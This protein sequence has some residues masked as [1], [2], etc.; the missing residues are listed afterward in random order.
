MTVRGMII[1]SEPIL[2]AISEKARSH[3]Q[4]GSRHLL[5]PSCRVRTRLYALKD[6]R[7]KCG[8]C[9]GKFT[10]SKKTDAVKL[11]QI[12]DLILCFC[13]NF[14]ARQASDLTSYRYRLV[15]AVY[16]DIRIL[17][18]RQTLVPGKLAL[19][20]AVEHCNRAVR[21]S[22]FCL[23]CRDR[24]G[25]RGRKSG[26]SPVFGVK[27]LAGDRVFIDPLQD[28]EADM[29]LGKTAA[30]YAGYAGFIC[31][32]RFH[33]FADNGRPQDGAER[34]WAWMHERLRKHH[35]IWKRNAGLYLKELEWK[36]NNR[37]LSTES[38]ALQ[39]ADLLP[40]DFLASWAGTARIRLDV[41]Q[42]GA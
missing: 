5:C 23:R 36:Y 21:E 31:R 42:S 11:R 32:G 26:D 4:D 14:P 37:L 19:L 20:T 24:F 40:D 28:G 16:G 41:V 17:L 38:Q 22:D 13:L 2:A 15:S 29:R 3:A 30:R 1:P 6:G 39:I 7:R 33:R 25:C 18:A 27:I 10:P 34:L 12:S 8:S 9:G 35:G